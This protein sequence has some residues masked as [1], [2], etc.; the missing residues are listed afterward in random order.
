MNFGHGESGV[1]DW[2]SA[3]SKPVAEY[4][5]VFNW[6][7]PMAADAAAITGF[8]FCAWPTRDTIP[9]NAAAATAVAVFF[10]MSA[11][12]TG[13]KGSTGREPIDYDAARAE[14]G[15]ASHRASPP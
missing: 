9:M 5:T 15:F 1:Y 14:H 12:V 6:S 13:A 10:N 7:T 3:K 11:S 4:W 8:A 2:P